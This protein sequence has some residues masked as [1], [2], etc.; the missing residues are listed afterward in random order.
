MADHNDDETPLDAATERL[1]RKMVRLLAISVATMM[2][3]VMAVLGAVV[4]KLNQDAAV[5]DPSAPPVEIALPQGAS[6]ADIAL[7]GDE[8]L[9]RLG[10]TEEGTLL[11]IDLRTG[12][13]IGRLVVTPR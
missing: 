8:A 6:I 11:R 2:L 9:L 3:G 13:V 7:D 4:Y 12:A 5:P 1:R 10:G